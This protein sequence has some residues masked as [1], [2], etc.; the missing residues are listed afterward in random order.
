[1][2]IKNQKSRTPLFSKMPVFTSIEL[3]TNPMSLLARCAKLNMKNS[4]ANPFLPYILVLSKENIM[5]SYVIN[6]IFA[7]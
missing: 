5:A 4:Q 3:V 7:C 6:V 2:S 1:M